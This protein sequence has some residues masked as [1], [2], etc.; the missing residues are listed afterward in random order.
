MSPSQ[1]DLVAEFVAVA[2]FFF[3]AFL[4]QM[5]D[6]FSDSEGEL[7]LTSHLSQA[8]KSV[9]VLQQVLGGL[10]ISPFL[11]PSFFFKGNRLIHLS[12]MRA[13]LAIADYVLLAKVKSVLFLHLLFLAPTIKHKAEKHRLLWQ[14]YFICQMKNGGCHFH[15]R[16]IY[17]CAFPLC[18]PPF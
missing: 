8:T 3:F 1:H 16:K 11:P 4:I 18:P 6:L 14:S 13:M 5:V 12:V 10:L 17:K 15:N 9:K 2:F 7:I